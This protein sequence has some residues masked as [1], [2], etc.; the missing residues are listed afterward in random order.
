MAAY[1]FGGR[2]ASAV[3]GGR[4]RQLSLVI[5]LVALCAT[6]ALGADIAPSKKDKC[7][8]C[9]M[10]VYM[11]KDW[12]SKVEFNDGST[13]YFDGPKD[14]LRY[15]MDIGKYTPG[16]AKADVK[17][18]L[19]TEYYDLEPMDAKAAFYVLGSDVM[20]PM[21]QELVP[22]KSEAQAMGFMRDHKGKSILK[23][24]E[25]SPRIMKDVR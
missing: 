20:G 23:F 22:F 1:C 18:I 11:Y 8:V 17:G 7:P 25:I 6:S 16:K 10:L 3:K 13:V 4:L 2:A 9:G 21:G 19:V 5:V 14:M 15:Y 12:G 24:L